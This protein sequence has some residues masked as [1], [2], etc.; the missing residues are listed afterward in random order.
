MKTL[1]KA[2][3]RTCRRAATNAV[4]L[5]KFEENAIN[6]IAVAMFD[7][8]A[9]PDRLAE[10][11]ESAAN[12]LGCTAAQ[13]V[14]TYVRDSLSVFNHAPRRLSAGLGVPEFDLG[15]ARKALRDT[16]ANAG[17][18]RIDFAEA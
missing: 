6:G 10:Q 8:D 15:C 13:L 7:Y 16:L 5:S 18:L 3:K 14:A 17:A 4:T 12:A 1:H 11:I 2:I 9:S